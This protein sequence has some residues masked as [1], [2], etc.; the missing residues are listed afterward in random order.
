MPGL[1]THTHTHT[2]THTPAHPPKKREGTT[3][4]AIEAFAQTAVFKGKEQ[5]GVWAIQRAGLSWPG[6][7]AQEE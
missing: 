2:D 1:H 5:G 4:R 6:V 3:G 7:L